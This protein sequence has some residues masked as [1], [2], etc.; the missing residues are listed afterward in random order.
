ML[1]GERVPCSARHCE[2]GLAYGA[3]GKGCSGCVR[4][5]QRSQDKGRQSRV[6]ERVGVGGPD[7]VD[8]QGGRGEEV[9][10]EDHEL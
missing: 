3:V 6:G 1:C 2:E 7:T 9:E 5:M 8:H 10:A 4:A